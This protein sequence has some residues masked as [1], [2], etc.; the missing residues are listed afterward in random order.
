MNALR[1]VMVAGVVLGSL[2]MS[3]TSFAG[4]CKQ[5]KFKFTNKVV[6]AT[7]NVDVKIKKIVA[8][9]NDGNWTE[10]IS[11]KVVGGNKSYTTG[12]RRLNKLDSGKRGDFTVHYERRKIGPGWASKT[13]S[14][15]NKKCWDG[16]TF[17][18][19]LTN[20]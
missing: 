9:G 13:Q 16:K 19:T 10:N 6:F 5:V 20:S 8:S 4:D 1:K 14:F 7:E 17:T 12:K 2:G 15:N 11:N 3:T 18:F